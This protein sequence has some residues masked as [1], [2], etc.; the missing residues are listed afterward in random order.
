MNGKTLG[1]FLGFSKF[2]WG[3]LSVKPIRGPW[4]NSKC[5]TDCRSPFKMSS[6]KAV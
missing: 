5:G 6:D 1:Y 2:A 4:A 3:S